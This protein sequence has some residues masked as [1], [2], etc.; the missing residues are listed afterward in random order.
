MASVRPSLFFEDEDK[1]EK[2][3]ERAFSTRYTTTMGIAFGRQTTKFD[4]PIHDN[5][6]LLDRN[7]RRHDDDKKYIG[8]FDDTNDARFFTYKPLYDDRDVRPKDPSFSK[9]KVPTEV[10]CKERMKKDTIRYNRQLNIEISKLIDY[11]STALEAAYFVKMMSYTTLWPPYHSNLEIADTTRNFYKLSKRE[12]NRY[13]F[14]MSH[15]FS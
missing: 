4:I 6:A 8:E 9:F 7:V 15:D 1:K 10:S 11:Q 14:I 13:D 2:K 12:Q 5:R 3:L